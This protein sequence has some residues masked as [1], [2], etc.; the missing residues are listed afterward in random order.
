MSRQKR[1]L[2]L[3]P[4]GEKPP[5]WSAKRPDDKK[6]DDSV[7]FRPAELMLR[8]DE[9]CTICQKLLVRPFTL[10][11]GKTICW[12]CLLSTERCPSCN[13][14]FPDARPGD[15]AS[16]SKRC[17]VNGKF[18]RIVDEAVCARY[19]EQ[20][21]DRV[22]EMMKVPQ[23][24]PTISYLKD[25]CP[26]GTPRASAAFV[27]GSVVI[28]V[29]EILVVVYNCA[30][31]Q[32]IRTPFPFECTCFCVIG[33]SILLLNNGRTRAHLMRVNL[34]TLVAETVIDHRI[35]GFPNSRLLHTDS[36]FYYR[37]SASSFVAINAVT[38]AHRFLLHP[39]M[40]TMHHECVSSHM[41]TIY[42]FYNRAVISW[43]LNH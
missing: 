1:P 17:V 32:E 25:N 14:Q 22:D 5:D 43:S 20:V 16:V 6:D 34:A 23:L 35:M 31:K 4:P 28:H 39:D 10:Q 30:T 12:F 40:I 7:G 38:G 15:L 13:I 37:T 26:Y 24:M 33:L 27:I 21:Q 29:L 2:S 18:N 11:C 36:Y 8:P 19:P 9:S 41:D 42:M 3:P